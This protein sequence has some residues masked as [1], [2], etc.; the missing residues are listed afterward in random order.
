MK[1][2]TRCGEGAVT[3]L[4]EA[5]WAKAAEAKLLRTT[6]WGSKMKR[7]RLT[8][9]YVSRDDCSGWHDR[10]LVFASARRGQAAAL[11]N[12]TRCSAARSARLYRFITQMQGP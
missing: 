2:T 11:L 8:C 3:G 9:G 12:R 6:L 7:R 5:L 10:A 1:L 4:N